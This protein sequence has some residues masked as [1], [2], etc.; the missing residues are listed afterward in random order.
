MQKG[1]IIGNYKI[2][3]EIGK[4]GMGEVY[5]AEDTKLNR[6]VALK[7]LLPE[8]A[9]DAER[10]ARFRQEA[11]SVSSLNHPHIITIFEILEIDGNICIVNEFI[12]GKTLRE[13][14]DED[15]LTL[16][17]S[18]RIAG[19]VADALAAAHKAHIIHRDIKP[20]NI[21]IREDGYAKIL[22]FGLAKPI[23]HQSSEEDATVRLVKTDPGMVMGSVR[24]M[25]PEQARGKETDERTDIWS[26]GVVLYEMFTGRNPFVADNVGD[27]M[28]AVLNKEPEPI[29]TYVTGSPGL[30]QEIISKALQKNVADRYSK[31]EDLAADLKKVRFQ[32][33]HDSNENKT[34]RLESDTDENETVIQSVSGEFTTREQDQQKDTNVSVRRNLGW[35]SAVAAAGLVILLVASGYYFVP[36]SAIF[37]TEPFDKFKSDTITSDQATQSAEISPDGKLVAFDKSELSAGKKNVWRNK[38]VIRQVEVGGENVI[39]EAENTVIKVEE[40]SNDGQYL[41]F[42]MPQGGGRETLY[43]IPVLGGKPKALLSG[44]GMSDINISPDGL[45]VAYRESTPDSVESSIYISDLDG[46]NAVKVVDLSELNGVFFASLDWSPDQSKL[47]LFY[48]E[49]DG[50]KSHTVLATY[51]LEGGGADALSKIYV[52]PVWATNRQIVWLNSGEGILI[53]GMGPKFLSRNQLWYV[54]YPDGKLRQVTNDTTQYVTI[55][56][57]AD[58]KNIVSVA[59]NGLGSLWSVDMNSKSARQIMAGRQDVRGPLSVGA[60]DRIY[61]ARNQENKAGIYS[62]DFEGRDE[63]EIVM[64]ASNWSSI[65]AYGDGKNLIVSRWIPETASRQIFRINADGTGEQQLTQMKNGHDRNISVADDGTIV[66]ERWKWVPPSEILMIPPGGGE[67]KPI[68]L[69]P[70]AK[71]DSLAISPNGEFL[72]YVASVRKDGTGKPQNLVRIVE[73]KNGVIGKKVLER[74]FNPDRIRWSPDSQSIVVGNRISD[75][76]SRIFL[77]GQSDAQITDFTDLGETFTGNFAFSRDG[78]RL[79]VQRWTF[80]TK[81]VRLRDTSGS[82]E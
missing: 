12:D 78:S 48:I 29:D 54:S 42:S 25:S 34:V 26:L 24:Y 35:R 28:V 47:A 40:F 9:G 53:R 76:L 50:E 62:I 57:S 20:E 55:S 71:N 46:S 4:G 22:D 14:I 69:E 52:G 10:V 81:I 41:F 37:G 39:F 6:K 74:E 3:S 38:L 77:S 13:K 45:K 79:F 68:K 15:K 18:I 72:A 21:M 63:Q 5:L 16:I 31:M 36:W 56:L 75:N 80:S 44:T 1:E 51:E 23:R 7:V 33:E 49:S 60:N 43:R 82:E 64:G 27:S 65:N 2:I 67:A 19:Q 66:F 58:G 11:I 32:L 73:F 59:R 30:L 70:D 8:I 61:I 17:E